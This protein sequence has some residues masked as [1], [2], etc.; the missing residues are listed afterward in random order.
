MDVFR[1]P[2]NTIV[3]GVVF[4]VV[5]ALYLLLAPVFDYRVEWAGVTMLGALAIAMTL[6]AYALI[7]GSSND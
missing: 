5:A 6:L 4:V 7:S 2:R 1:H 3:I